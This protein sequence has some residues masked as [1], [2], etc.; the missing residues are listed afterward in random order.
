MARLTREADEQHKYVFRHKWVVE[1]EVECDETGEW[2]TSEDM[3]QMLSDKTF[4][5]LVFNAIDD[6]DN[7]NAMLTE[8]AQ[9]QVSDAITGFALEL[10]STGIAT[11]TVT[12]NAT[13][14]TNVVEQLGDWI[15]GQCSDGYGEGLE[16]Q[17]MAEEKDYEDVY[18]DDEVDEDGNPNEL[19]RVELRYSYAVK[20]YPSS[21]FNLEFVKG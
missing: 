15:T 4:D 9:E 20:L 8:I 13:L 5:E 1:T 7:S 12:T 17:P 3:P 10:D 2:S 21:D 18:L 14:D 16:Q 19:T 11:W 6:F